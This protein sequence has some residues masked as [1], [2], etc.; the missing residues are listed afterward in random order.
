VWAEMFHHLGSVALIEHMAADRAAAELAALSGA[1]G[2][3]LTASPSA[4][5]PVLREEALLGSVLKPLVGDEAK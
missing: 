2:F 3:T 5:S 4:D 1:P